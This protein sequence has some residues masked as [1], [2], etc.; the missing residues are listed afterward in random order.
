MSPMHLTDKNNFSILRIHP[1]NQQ[2]RDLPLHQLGRPY[3]KIPAAKPIFFDGNESDK[4]DIDVGVRID[5]PTPINILGIAIDINPLAAPVRAVKILHKTT[6]NAMFR[7]IHHICK[8][9]HK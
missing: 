3:N 1:D 6:P 7:S 2:L 8:N 4:R 9:A 5:S